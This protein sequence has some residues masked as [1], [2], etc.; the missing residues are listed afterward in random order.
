MCCL[1]H[2]EHGLS[3][4]GAAKPRLCLVHLGSPLLRT[5]VSAILAMVA[6]V[7]SRTFLANKQYFFSLIANQRI[8][9]SAMIFQPNE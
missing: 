6:C 5:I 2:D 4:E 8:V 1:I 7:I 9:L 3:D